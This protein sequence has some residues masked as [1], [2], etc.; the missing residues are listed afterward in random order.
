MFHHFLLWK[1][2]KGQQVEGTVNAG[3]SSRTTTRRGLSLR[4]SYVLG[5]DH[6]MVHYE[7]T[8]SSGF[9]SQ[10]EFSVLG[11]LMFLVPPVQYLTDRQVG[12]FYH[13]VVSTLTPGHTTPP[14]QQ[15]HVLPGAEADC[16]FLYLSFATAQSTATVRPVRQKS[17]V[18]KPFLFLTFLALV[19][20]L[21]TKHSKQPKE[22]KKLPIQRMLALK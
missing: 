8:S 10:Q 17:D 12:S 1:A 5:P 9:L 16:V 2:G 21:F 6:Q 22:T 15:H 3:H 7:L 14:S 18:R 4:R 13:R 20:D 11:T 19:N